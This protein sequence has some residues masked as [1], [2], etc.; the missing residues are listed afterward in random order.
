MRSGPSAADLNRENAGWKET[1][2]ADSSSV[3]RAGWSEGSWRSTRVRGRATLA[4]CAWAILERRRHA[5]REGDGRR[6]VTDFVGA[7]AQ[8]VT[9]EAR[10]SRQSRQS[11]QKP[12]EQ[13]EQAEQAKQAKQ[14][15]REENGL[16]LASGT[17]ERSKRLPRAL[18][19]IDLPVEPASPRRGEAERAR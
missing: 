11:R 6:Q 2:G 7:G 10:Q 18:R 17:R 8:A 4:G 3:G 16:G 5:T 13:A 12:A 15:E 1:S 14:A 9:A 19:S